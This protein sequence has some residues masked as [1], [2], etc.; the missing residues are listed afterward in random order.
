MLNPRVL[1]LVP[2]LIKTNPAGIKQNRA[3]IKTNPPGI[4]PIRAPIGTNLPGIQQSRAENFD[5]LRR[6]WK[7]EAGK[8]HGAAAVSHR[9]GALK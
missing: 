9:Q 2:A 1:K 8:L 4:K 7:G 3:G 5:R 6:I